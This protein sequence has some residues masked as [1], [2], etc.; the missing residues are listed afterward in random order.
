LGITITYRLS[1]FPCP[2]SGG[3]GG[4]TGD[5]DGGAEVGGGGILIRI[6]HKEVF[7]T[8]IELTY[9]KHHSSSSE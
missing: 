6:E 4:G 3:Y 1:K 5:L 9:F 8:R 2:I 7:R